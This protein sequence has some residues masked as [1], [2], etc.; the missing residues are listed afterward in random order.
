MKF[1]PIKKFTISIPQS[2]LDT[3]RGIFEGLLDEPL[4]D[5]ELLQELFF[6]DDMSGS[7]DGRSEVT[8]TD[9]EV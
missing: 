7:Y 2:H 1:N 5:T 4:S 6:V 8:V 9:K 3:L